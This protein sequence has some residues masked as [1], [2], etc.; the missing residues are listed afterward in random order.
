MFRVIWLFLFVSWFGT[1]AA[2]QN[3]H[4]IDGEIEIIL[5]DGYHV[6]PEAFDISEIGQSFSGPLNEA[7]IDR[8]LSS[9]MSG[10]TATEYLEYMIAN[11]FLYDDENADVAAI[12]ANLKNLTISVIAIVPDADYDP[13]SDQLK[14]PASEIKSMSDFCLRF[15]RGFKSRWGSGA[16][17]VFDDDTQICHN[18]NVY[19]A[20]NAVH[21]LIVDTFVVSVTGIDWPIAFLP[22]YI[23]DV[24]FNK[25]V[26]QRNPTLGRLDKFDFESATNEEKFSRYSGA[27]NTKD[28]VSVLLSAKKKA[29]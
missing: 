28:A 23:N 26:K 25:T 19:G 17:H 5:P 11:E 29:P 12:K 20:L 16:F 3:I 24:S 13:K 22:D 10:A 1:I 21:T 2:A 4:F 18:V 14:I 27:A 8:A 15:S 9:H 7:Q 6:T